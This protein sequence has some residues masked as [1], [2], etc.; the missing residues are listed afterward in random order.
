MGVEAA[1]AQYHQMKTTHSPEAF[2][3]SLLN[4]LGYRLLR[5]DRVQD[6]IIVF[7]LNAAEY[8]DA[9]NP[10]D[11]LGEAYLAAGDTARAIKNYEKSVELDPGNTN[12]LAVLERIRR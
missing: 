7:E 10:Y 11:S 9:S 1:I 2:D 3:E 6:A 5:A 8:P 12:G 4:T